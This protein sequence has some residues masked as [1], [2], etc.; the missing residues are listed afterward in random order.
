MASF[1]D[2]SRRKFGTRR[3]SDQVQGGGFIKNGSLDQG[4]RQ[5]R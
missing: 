5:W 3:T 4:W 2:K 1:D